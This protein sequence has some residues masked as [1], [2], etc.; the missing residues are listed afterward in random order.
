MDVKKNYG[1]PGVTLSISIA[2]G[3]T[4]QAQISGNVTFEQS[5]IIASAKQQIGLTFSASVTTTATFSGSWAVPESATEGW[6]GIGAKADQTTWKKYQQMGN[7][8]D[9]LVGSGTDKL[10]WKYPYFHH[11]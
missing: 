5:A 11:S 4:L 9:K 8:T 6:V 1:G 3:V 7:C 2:A 10:P